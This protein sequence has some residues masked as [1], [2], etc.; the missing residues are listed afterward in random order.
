MKKNVIILESL[1]S[2]IRDMTI[3]EEAVV[4]F[5]VHPCLRK[6]HVSFE[7]RHI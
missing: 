5:S 6:I 4:G 1:A 3:V 7:S 2:R